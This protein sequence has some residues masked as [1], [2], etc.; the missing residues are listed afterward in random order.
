[1]RKLVKLCFVLGLMGALSTGLFANGINLNSIGSKAISMGGA[2][3]GLADDFSAV[4]WNPAGLTQMKNSSFTLMGSAIIPKVTYK[5]D[6]F[7]PFGGPSIDIESE[8]AVYPNPGL[9][10]FKVMSDNLVIGVLLFAPSGIG[11]EWDGDNLT[12]FSSD[13]TT[14]YKWKSQLGAFT[15]APAIAYKVSDTFSIGAA[16][17]L[18]YGMMTIDRAGL[19]QYSEDLDG[20]FVNGAIG[21]LFTPSKLIS[22]GATVKLPSKLTLKGDATMAGAGLI[23]FSTTSEAERTIDWPMWIGVGVAIKPTDKLTITADAQYTNWEK[24]DSVPMVFTDPM[25]RLFF[26][27]DSS[28]NTLWE[29]KIQYRFGVQYLVSESLAVRAGYY[30]DDAPAPGTTLNILMPSISSNWVTFGLGYMT[31]KIN[32][33]FGFEYNLGGKDRD[34]DIAGVI[35]GDA[36][37]GTHGLSIFVPTLSFTLKF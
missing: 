8:K 18:N 15:A 32:L 36:M 31:E 27:A 28:M 24:I 6:F 5:T 37:P 1:M 2:F 10:Y 17:Y 7:V 25:W 33:D 35:A 20:F 22:I 34:A 30:I 4:F 16:L 23:G 12:V 9:G 13:M 21:A 19:G 26:E 11:S 3:V 29:D 14:S